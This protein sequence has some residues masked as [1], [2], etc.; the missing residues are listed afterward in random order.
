MAN[1]VDEAGGAKVNV[2]PFNVQVPRSLET[3]WI[4]DNHVDDKDNVVLLSRIKVKGHTFEFAWPQ[5]LVVS[6]IDNISAL[7]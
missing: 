3:D 4:D 2:L 6:T 1:F 5:Y 7:T